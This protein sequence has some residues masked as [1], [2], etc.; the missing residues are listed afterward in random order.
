VANKNK[1]RSMLKLNKY[2]YVFLGISAFFLGLLF[3]TYNQQS[4]KCANSISCI[5]DLS[6]KIDQKEKIG[7]Y[8]N[9]NILIPT[10]LAQN[11]NN[12]KNVLG[13]NTN[14]ANKHIY[15]DLT[16]Q[17]LYAKENGITKFE[18]L[19]SSGKW[20]KTPTGDFSIWIKL[21][22]TRM[23]GGNKNIGTF[24]DLPNVPYTMYFYN[25]EVPK[26]KGFGLHGAYWHNNFGHPMSHGCV[27]ISPENA[28]TLYYWAD[29][30]TIGLST[31]ADS[32]NPGTPITIYGVAPP[33]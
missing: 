12:S 21:R 18:F 9:K 1:K 2:S 22:A 10:Q 31:K 27:N 14:K 16:S 23:T 7:Y 32:K 5:K 28:K 4:A 11:I 24:Y 13:D 30:P 19:I 3:W 20:G 6:G 26:S 25:N 29:P 17:K 15:V 33:Q 8:E